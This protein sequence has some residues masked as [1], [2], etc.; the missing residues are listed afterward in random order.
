MRSLIRPV[1]VVCLLLALMILPFGM[2]IQPAL[3]EDATDRKEELDAAFGKIFKQYKTVGASVLVCKDDQL[4]YRRNFGY[5]NRREEQLVDDQ[6]YFLAASISKFVT[7]IHVMQLVERGILDLDSDI[8]TWL[9]YTVRNPYFKKTPLTL[10]MLMTHT[11]SVKETGSFSNNPKIGLQAM[12]GEGRKSAF[13]NFYK[14]EPGRKYRY[15][16]F[17]AGIIGCIVEAVTGK[18]FNDSITEDLF[19]PLGIDAAYSGTLLANPDDI[20]Y[21]YTAGAKHTFQARSKTL[22]APWDSSVNPDTHFKVS[23][24]SLW[25]RPADLCKLARMLCNG[26]TVDGVTILQPETVEEMLSEQKGKGDVLCDTPYGLNVHREKT[27]LK[28]SLFYGHQGKIEDLLSNVYFEPESGFVFVLM[29]NGC[30]SKMNDH[31]AIITRKLF[32]LSW[33]QFSQ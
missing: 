10:R 16:N 23:F 5:S 25:I 28:G 8:S 33:K 3:T 15:S 2:L 17:G 29:T 4:V 31:V 18:N 24:G 1:R 11:A 14:T 20:S 22:N 13:G 9:G 26:G 19:V 7:A 30:S 32:E 12:I 21:L 27:L 6:T